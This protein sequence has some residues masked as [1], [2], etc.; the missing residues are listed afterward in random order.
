MSIHYISLLNQWEAEKN[1]L[2]SI[3]EKVLDL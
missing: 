1:D 3:I 2:I